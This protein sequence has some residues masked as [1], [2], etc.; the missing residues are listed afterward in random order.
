MLR[1]ELWNIYEK[2]FLSE[3]SSIKNKNRTAA[4]LLDD[5]LEGQRN[6]QQRIATI[7]SS[8]STIENW[9][10]ILSKLKFFEDES[11]TIPLVSTEDSTIPL[12][13]I[14]VEVRSSEND[15]FVTDAVLNF[16]SDPYQLA[17]EI[18]VEHQLPAEEIDYIQGMLQHGKCFINYVIFRER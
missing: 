16:V 18:Q 5:A 11:D 12:T 6:A 13:E 10:S 8:D 3:D 15:K 4:S 2:V 1:L 14:T 9:E 17:C 7:F